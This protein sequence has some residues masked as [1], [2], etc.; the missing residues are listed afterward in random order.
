MRLRFRILDLMVLVV[1]CAVAAMAVRL[2]KGELLSEV[3]TAAYLTLVCLATVGAKFHRGNKQRKVFWKGVAFFG[4][5]YFPV[6]LQFGFPKG[7]EAI[8]RAG[9]GLVFA[10]ACGYATARLV[11]RRLVRPSSALGRAEV[12]LTNPPV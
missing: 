7:E 11:P 5:V 10:L 4:W 9:I 6:G 8:Y 3:A 2:G 12:D 1:P